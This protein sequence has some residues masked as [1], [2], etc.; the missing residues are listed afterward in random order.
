[1]ARKLATGA[2]DTEIRSS[3]LRTAIPGKDNS[4]TD[5]RIDQLNDRVELLAESVSTL[6]VRLDQFMESASTSGGGAEQATSTQMD[7]PEDHPD[8]TIEIEASGITNSQR[9]AEIAFVPTHTVKTRLNLRPS[10]S[11]VEAPI[12]LLG[13]GTKVRYINEEDG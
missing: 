7:I 11:L 10:S 13:A 3:D 6:E 2:K 1:M 12:A 4:R 5:E 9:E 8:S